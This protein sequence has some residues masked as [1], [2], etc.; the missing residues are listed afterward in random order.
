MLKSNLMRDP[1]GCLYFG[2]LYL[3][4]SGFN[5]LVG[6]FILVG[7]VCSGGLYIYFGG[8]S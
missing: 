6:Y 5:M 2:G 1:V 7:Y 4:S 8:L 3:Y